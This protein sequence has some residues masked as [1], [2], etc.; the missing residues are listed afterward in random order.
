[1]RTL[2]SVFCSVQSSLVMHSFG[3]STFSGTKS[4]A[5]CPDSGTAL[6]YS[7]HMGEMK[8]DGYLDVVVVI[9]VVFCLA[10]DSPSLG[11]CP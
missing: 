6:T 5:G 3:Y 11:H 2:I 8:S 9:G 10:P 4:C 1:M 7:R